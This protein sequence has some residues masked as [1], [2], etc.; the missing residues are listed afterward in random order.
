MEKQNMKR[1][2]H[3]LPVAL[4]EKLKKRAEQAGTPMSEHV[5]AALEAYLK[6]E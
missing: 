4:I 6:A 1:V 2:N 3:F 5:R